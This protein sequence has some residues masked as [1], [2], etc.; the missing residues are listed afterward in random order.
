MTASRRGFRAAAVLTLLAFT[1]ATAGCWRTKP[2]TELQ[3][4]KGKG[5]QSN[6]VRFVIDPGNLQPYRAVKMEVTKVEFP[7]AEGVVREE[8]VA[9]ADGAWRPWS[10]GSPTATIDLR[11][12][13]QVEVFDS[14]YGVGRVILTIFVVIGVAAAV[15]L[16]VLLIAVI[17]KACP[18]LYVDRGGGMEFVGVPYAGATFRS[19]QRDDLLPLTGLPAGTVQMKLIDGGLYETDYTDRVELVLVDH[20]PALQALP[21]ADA[22]VL[23]VGQSVAPVAAHDLTGADRL[24]EVRAKDGKVY[25]TDL[26][27]A[28]RQRDPALRDG[29][30]AVFAPAA[31]PRAL[32]VVAGTTPWIDLV[33][34]NYAALFGD[35]LGLYVDRWNALEKRAEVL[36]WRD[37][38]GVDLRVEQK[39]D[40]QWRTVAIVPT[41]GPQRAFAVPLGEAKASEPIEVRVSGGAGFWS[42]DQLALAPLVGEAQARRVPASVALDKDGKDMRAALAATDGVY[43]VLPEPGEELKLAFDVPPVPAGKQRAAFFASTGYYNVRKT[44]GANW[45]PAKLTRIGDGPGALARFSLEL[46][47]E[48]QKIALESSRRPVMAEPPRR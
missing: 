14:A 43:Q 27:Q 5:L 18:M 30:E 9:I 15:A 28:H 13:R 33:F 1:S 11:Q 48:Y 34:A 42:F 7:F 29:I 22:R 21:T 31:G 45:S 39:R 47:G 16:A 19:I 20:D 38:Q 2:I 46:F 10:S 44:D 37:Q 24:A 6:L 23:L 8:E 4:D 12:V 40:G 36:A 17:T 3:A 32:Q 35:R 25:Q 41:P 26:D